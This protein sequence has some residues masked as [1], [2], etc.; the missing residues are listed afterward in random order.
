MSSPTGNFV[1]LLA[2]PRFKHFAEIAI[3]AERVLVH[4]RAS[5]IIN[6]RRALE[7]AVR[8]LYSV[9]TALVEPWKDNLAGMLSTPEF[10][11]L[12]GEHVYKRLE[13]IRNL[14]NK[15]AH[16]NYNFKEEEALLCLEQLHILMSFMARCYSKVKPKG[17]FNAE[18]AKTAGCTAQQAEP[19]ESKPD[20]RLEELLRENAALKEQLTAQRK[21]EQKHIENE[22]PELCEYKTRKLYIDAMLMNAGWVEGRDWINEVELSGM[23]NKAGKGYADYVLYDKA[24]LAL[25]VVEAKKTSIGVEQGRQQAKLYADLIERQQGIRPVIFLTNGFDTYIIDNQY[26]ERRVAEIYSRRDLEKLHNLRRTRLSLKHA[27]V[28]SKIA[29]RYYQKEAIK[30]TCQAF[31]EENR[32]KALLVMATGSG[33]TR[34]VIALCKVLLQMGWVKNILFLADRTALVT[35]AKR[36]FSNMLPELSLT[37]LV[38]EKDNLTARCVFSTYNTMMN[39]IDNA[40]D[41]EGNRL[42]TC[43]HFDLLICDEAHRSIY[44]KYRDIFNYFDSPL[45]GLTATP[46]DDIDK[47]TYGIFELEAGVPTY[48][49]DLA[50]AVKD[51]YLVDYVTIESKLKLMS[52]GIV[53]DELSDEEKEE[54]E[55][56]FTDEEGQLPE[57]IEASALNSRVFNTDTIRHVLSILMQQGIRVDYGN[58]IAKSIIFARNHAHAEKILEV[59]NRE[60]PQLTG[61]AM[62]IDNYLNYAQSA[63]DD[64]SNPGKLPQIAITVDMLDTGIDVPEVANLV[65][66]KKVMSRAKFWQMIGRGTRLCPGLLDG[67]DKK[68]FFIFDFCSNFEFFRLNAKGKESASVTTIQG[69]LFTLKAQI[70]SRLQGLNYQTEDLTEFR[71]RLVQEML[72][73]VQKLNRDNFAV[74]QHLRIVEQYARPEGYQS[75]SYEDTENI[76]HELA[77]LIDPEPDEA[78]ALRFDA[79]MYGIE[80]AYLAGE[81][82]PQ[83]RRR[84]EIRSKVAAISTVS[85]IPEIAAKKALIETILQTQYLENAD[86]NAFEHIRTQ[87]REL[88]KYLPRESRRYDTN[89][90]DE[91]IETI[92]GHDKPE[93]D[94]LKTYREK[95]ESYLKKHLDSVV[96]SK[97]KNNIALTAADMKEL[98]RILWHEV[99][100]REAYEEECGENM[101][102]GEFVRS[103][104]GLE[105]SAA[106]AAFARFLDDNHLNAAQIYFVNRIIEFIVQNGLM[107]DMRVL[108]APPFTNKGDIVG[109]FSH[110]MPL[111]LEIRK[112]IESINATAGVA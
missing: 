61:Q 47:N 49:Y 30:A 109:L 57:K 18:L 71:E 59:F 93:D 94:L 83:A 84:K 75:L 80:Q 24:G 17:N 82:E 35:Q 103:I 4:D 11:K 10:R 112:T 41:E 43:G 12:I 54:Y 78:S 76:R 55:Q 37:N 64:F 85:N 51:G 36:A 42:F 46:K 31:D 107:K 6:C 106:K 60:Y 39:C 21:E 98:E 16:S 111:L 96:I 45:V 14:G 15:A 7:C 102:L 81:K 70:I 22:P 50:Q 65:F 69:A 91:V 5:A 56:T 79:L 20:P 63:I 92:H 2:E 68:E 86:V 101:P 28:D 97:L 72:S 67:A 9:D 88:M 100:T 23:P 32:R 40:Q 25:A 104:V 77:P 66:F 38:E 105:M 33:K 73:K 3:A 90:D 62:V 13:Y 26:Q 1:F 108:M 87:L 8:W 44:N 89:F 95:A 74:H 58:K 53:Y 48:G 99:G 27:E 52:D 110:N 34:T 19:I 29:G